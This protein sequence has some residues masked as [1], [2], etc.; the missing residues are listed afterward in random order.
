MPSIDEMI[1]VIL[2]KESVD[3]LNDLYARSKAHDFFRG[4]EKSNDFFLQVRECIVKNAESFGFDM[5]KHYERSET[6]LSTREMIE[7]SVDFAKHLDIDLYEKVINILFDDKT[8]LKT[9]EPERRESN[10]SVGLVDGIIE[11]NLEPQ[12]NLHGLMTVVHEIVG[13]LVEQRNQEK[14]EQ[15][16]DSVVEISSLFVERLVLDYFQEQGMMTKE[17][18]DREVAFWYNQRIGDANFILQERHICRGVEPPFT[19]EKLSDFIKGLE[20]DKNKDVIVG[21]L[22]KQS[23]SPKPRTARFLYR[24]IVGT[25]VASLMYEDWKKDPA[26][27]MERYKT[28]ISKNAEYKSSRYAFQDLLGDDYEKRLSS[29]LESGT[30][31]K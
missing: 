14:C 7:F 28:F 25:V 5:K 9:K 21:H 18:H 10:L 3:R 30:K 26:K 4:F 16:I 13:H 6:H 31:T 1:Q 15:K 22:Y 24:Y 2:K 27:T 17:E 19:Q 12:N 29:L 8:V 11:I 20:G 23:T